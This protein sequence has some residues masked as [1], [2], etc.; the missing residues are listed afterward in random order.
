MIQSNSETLKISFFS[1]FRVVYTVFPINPNPTGTGTGSR[2]R[3]F[4]CT[5]VYLRV[6]KKNSRE[7]E[8]VREIR[9]M[10]NVQGR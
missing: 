7:S 1:N 3:L 5:V 8:G 10:K 2:N 6:E 9:Y 4:K